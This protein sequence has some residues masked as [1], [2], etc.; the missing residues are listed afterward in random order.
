VAV[1]PRG[2]EVE[3]VFVD[4]LRTHQRRSHRSDGEGANE[5]KAGC[6]CADLHRC[7]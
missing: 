4:Y 5:D 6:R 3:A 1:H 7:L 2:D